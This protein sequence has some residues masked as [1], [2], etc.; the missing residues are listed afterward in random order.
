MSK[1]VKCFP[2]NVSATILAQSSELQTAPVEQSETKTAP[3]TH[4]RS[5][6]QFNVWGLLFF[7]TVYGMIKK[8]YECIYQD[9]HI[10]MRIENITLF[11]EVNKFAKFH[12]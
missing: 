8:H 4:P 7:S 11:Y 9:V 2:N 12:F 1:Q 3:Q 10:V 6:S 5:L